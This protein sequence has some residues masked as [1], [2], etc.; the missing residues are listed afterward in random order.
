MPNIIQAQMAK[1]RPRFGDGENA[2]ILDAINFALSGQNTVDIPE[3]SRVIGY[4]LAYIEI[5]MPASIAQSRRWQA[6]MPFAADS[7]REL[8]TERLAMIFDWIWDAVMPIFQPVADRV[9]FGPQ[10]HEAITLRSEPVSKDFTKLSGEDRHDAWT[11]LQFAVAAEKLFKLPNWAV[12]PEE[13]PFV[14]DAAAVHCAEMAIDVAALAVYRL[15]GAVVNSAADVAF[16]NWYS[17]GVSEK[18]ADVAA[19]Q[20]GDNARKGAWAQINPCGLL[21]GLISCQ[22]RQDPPKAAQLS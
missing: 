22:S 3:M 8:E 1:A 15:V 19:S 7:G 14:R 20:A 11:A 21:E 4:W 2:S 10:W 13:G 17:V 16:A 5:D 18:D 12:D 9:G 6:L